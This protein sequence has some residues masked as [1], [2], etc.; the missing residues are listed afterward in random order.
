VLFNIDPRPYEATLRQAE[1][2]FLRDTA[3][4][5]QA[6]SQEQR[7][8]D[9]L[10]K[11]FVSKEAYAQSAPTPIQPGRWPREAVPRSTTRS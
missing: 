1:A 2:N 8:K 6:R 9:L 11:N 5:D 7:Y 10:E 3:Q 4:K